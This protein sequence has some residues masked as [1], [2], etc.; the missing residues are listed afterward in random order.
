MEQIQRMAGLSGVLLLTLAFAAG[1]AGYDNLG[2]LLVAT[3]AFLF[4][5]SLFTG[6]R[7]SV[8]DQ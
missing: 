4:A 8:R 3:A 1:L 2:W 7:G 6:S 5:L